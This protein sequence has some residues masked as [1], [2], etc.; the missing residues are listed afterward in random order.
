MVT[1]QSL[2]EQ[3]TNYDKFLTH[4]GL[5]PQNY[6][7][8]K[9]KFFALVDKSIEAGALDFKE[10]ALAESPFFKESLSGSTNIYE[11]SLKVLRMTQNSLNE[12]KDEVLKIK[13]QLDEISSQ[14]DD[15]VTVSNVNQSSFPSDISKSFFPSDIIKPFFPVSKTQSYSSINDV[16]IEN[17]INSLLNKYSNVDQTQYLDLDLY[18]SSGI[19]K[20]LTIPDDDDDERN[21]FIFKFPNEIIPI[22]EF[23]DGKDY[24]DYYAICFKYPEGLFNYED[25]DVD[26]GEVS[27]K[28]DKIMAESLAQKLSLIV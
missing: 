9:D 3:H 20:Y 7:T 10:I 23:E 8:K 28:Y 19:V 1:L 26:V 11:A 16:R 13:Q 4:F 21:F 18:L 5:N 12:S 25:V 24:S 22:E 2:I 6:Q 14:V 27:V 17:S 15:L